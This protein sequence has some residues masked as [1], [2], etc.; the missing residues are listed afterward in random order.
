MCLVSIGKTSPWNSLATED[1]DVIFGSQEIRKI[2]VMKTIY[3]ICSLLMIVMI[4]CSLQK[5]PILVGCICFGIGIGYMGV[6]RVY[7]SKE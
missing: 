2:K 7:E 5:Y 4:S 6:K 3:F 1:Q